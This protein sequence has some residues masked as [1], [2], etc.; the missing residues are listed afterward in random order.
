MRR[1]G[2]EVIRRDANADARAFL[3][4]QVTRKQRQHGGAGLE[5]QRVQNLRALECSRDD[6]SL[7]PALG[8]P[9]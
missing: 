7:K 8:E 4:I 6:R 3:V 1:E 9:S 5:R 2:D